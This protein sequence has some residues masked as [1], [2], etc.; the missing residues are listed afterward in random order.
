MSGSD[1]AHGEELF[2]R[3]FGVVIRH[4]AH[5][6]ELFNRHDAIANASTP[7]ED[8]EYGNKDF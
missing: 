6:R 8:A 5:E 1:F 3:L 2:P 7:G 4:R